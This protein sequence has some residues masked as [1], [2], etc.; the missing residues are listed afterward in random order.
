[1]KGAALV[2]DNVYLA[3]KDQHKGLNS[4]EL[5]SA[6]CHNIEI[7]RRTQRAVLC[8]RQARFN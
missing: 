1:M 7:R 3:T 2:R 8:S 6:N 5:V 4:A